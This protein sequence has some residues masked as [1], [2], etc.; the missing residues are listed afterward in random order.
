MTREAVTGGMTSR[1]RDCP[2]RAE[3]R[4]GQRTWDVVVG[5]TTRVVDTSTQV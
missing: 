1:W 5:V 2:R 4:A 3:E